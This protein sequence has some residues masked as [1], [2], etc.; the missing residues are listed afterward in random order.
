[1]TAVVDGVGDDEAGVSDLLCDEEHGRSAVEI[2]CAEL[3]TEGRARQS[4]GHHRDERIRIAPGRVEV[5]D[6]FV[7]DH[8]GQMQRFAENGDVLFEGL[9]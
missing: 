2:V 9:R 4:S 1:M 5:L 7:L 8:R 6:S 3:K